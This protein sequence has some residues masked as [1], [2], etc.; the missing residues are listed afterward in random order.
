MLRCARG[1]GR[2]LGLGP[3]VGLLLGVREA[4]AQGCGVHG[5][6][7]LHEVAGGTIVDTVVGILAVAL[8]VGI[9]RDLAS[10]PAGCEALVCPLIPTAT[11]LTGGVSFL[12]AHYGYT[13]TARCRH[14][15]GARR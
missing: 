12:S 13:R 10:N 3:S 5:P 7:A 9:A 1:E 2:R 6:Q 4:A 14:L 15:R 8:M 11:G